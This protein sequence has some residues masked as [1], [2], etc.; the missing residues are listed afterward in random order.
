MNIEPTL[1]IVIAI[2]TVFYTGINLFM[3]IESKAVRLQKITP[4]VVMYLKSSE[5]HKTLALHVKNI[6]EGIAYDVRIKTLKDYNQFGQENYPISDLGVLK[7]G[8]AAMPPNYELK[9]YVGDIL[10]VYEKDR[11]GEVKFEVEYE[12]KDSKNFKEVFNLS[13]IQ[14]IGQSYSTPPESFLGQIPHYLKEIST[15]LKRIEVKI[16]KKI[17]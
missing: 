2:S 1:S 10:D 15:I 3:L 8:F 12:R 11:D 13:F 5:D 9:F 14:A 6:G 16:E 7:H 4:H 17:D